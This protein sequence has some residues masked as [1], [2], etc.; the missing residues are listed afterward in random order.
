MI[1]PTLIA[2]LALL[3]VTLCG[4]LWWCRVNIELADRREAEIIRR[5]RPVPAVTMTAT[6]QRASWPHLSPARTV[7]TGTVIERKEIGP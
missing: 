7:L 1:L 5:T 2:G 6:V 3:T 4:L